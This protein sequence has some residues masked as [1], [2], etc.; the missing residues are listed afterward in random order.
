MTCRGRSRELAATV[1]GADLSRRALSATRATVA[2]CRDVRLAPV[3]GGA[4]AVGEATLA[5]SHDARP[6]TARETLQCQRVRPRHARPAAWI[7]R[8]VGGVSRYIDTRVGHRHAAA[9]C[10]RTRAD[11]AA[12]PAVGGVR[13]EVPAGVAAESVPDDARTSARRQAI[14]VRRAARVPRCVGAA[15]FGDVHR[16]DGAQR[17]ERT[18]NPCVERDAMAF[19]ADRSGA[20]EAAARVCRSVGRICDVHRICRGSNGGGATCS[21]WDRE[22]CERW[23]LHDGRSYFGSSLKRRAESSSE[24]FAQTDCCAGIRLPNGAHGSR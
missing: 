10:A 2:S 20:A 3:D 18:F 16:V 24:L 13:V 12:R 8:R 1:V 14:C 17:I 6:A 21:E 15:I 11:V 19:R 7:R 23:E 22:E 9:R 5:H 4:V